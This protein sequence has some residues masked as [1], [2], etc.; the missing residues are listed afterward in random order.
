[1]KI[2]LIKA[3]LKDTKEIWEMQVKAF[4]KLLD[5]YQDFETNP[6]SEPISNIE[7]RL[8][9]NFTFFYFICVDSKKVGA[10]RIVDHREENKNSCCKLQIVSEPNLLFYY[11]VNTNIINL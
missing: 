2:E 10:I 6:A 3:T 5:K 8:K 9:Q 1:M 7:M 11:E 4:K